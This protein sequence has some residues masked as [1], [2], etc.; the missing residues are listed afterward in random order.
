MAMPASFRPP[1]IVVEKEP[2]PEV[3]AHKDVK[4]AKAGKGKK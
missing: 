4:G 2:E 1:P 3:E